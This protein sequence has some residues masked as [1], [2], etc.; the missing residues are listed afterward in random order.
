MEH[1]KS[2]LL[3]DAQNNKLRYELIFNSKM[4]NMCRNMHITPTTMFYDN[5]ISITML[6]Y[7]KNNSVEFYNHN[8]YEYMTKNTIKRTNFSDIMLYYSYRENLISKIDFNN[9]E[10]VDCLSVLHSVEEDYQIDLDSIDDLLNIK[11]KRNTLIQQDI[12]SNKSGVK[13]TISRLVLGYDL[14]SL[15]EKIESILALPSSLIPDETIEKLKYIYSIKYREGIDLSEYFMVV[16]NYRDD[17]D[18]AIDI[19]NKACVSSIIPNLTVIKNDTEEYTLKGENFSFLVHKIAG[20]TDFKMRDRICKDY[21]E[22]FNN[23]DINSTLSSSLI[24]QYYMGLVPVDDPIIGFNTI[25]STDILAMGIDDIFSDDDYYMKHTIP[26]SSSLFLYKTFMDKCYNDYNEIVLKRNNGTGIIKPDYVL[27]LQYSETDK[28]FY[29]IARYFKVPI[30]NIDMNAY[31]HLMLEHLDYLCKQNNLKDYWLYFVKMEKSFINHE[32]MIVDSLDIN[33]IHQ[34]LDDLLI[35][36]NTNMYDKK[37]CM[38][39]NRIVMLFDNFLHE[40]S[41][42][43]EQNDLEYYKYKVKKLI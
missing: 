43:K 33:K 24:N 1:I 23:N 21:S 20:L 6:N 32:Y 28:P 25:K 40:F 8:L 17:L 41:Y 4:I 14:Y 10:Q 37:T 7:F 22:W 29:D 36:V 11:S 2:K 5:H 42:N 35:N 16:Q 15:Y 31:L 26:H 12:I 19:A 38:D 3:K 9:D 30:Y 13:D 27:N 34:I 39:I 18:T